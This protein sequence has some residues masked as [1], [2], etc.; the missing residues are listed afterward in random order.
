MDSRSETPRSVELL[1]FQ[2]PVTFDLN[3]MWTDS[4]DYA[5]QLVVFRCGCA[6][7]FNRESGTMQRDK[8]SLRRG[9]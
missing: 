6:Y 5:S 3:L 4:N 1:R 9:K 8:S 7:L 2:P